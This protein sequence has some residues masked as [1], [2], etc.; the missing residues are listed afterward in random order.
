[1][2]E[3]YKG[4]VF[5]LNGLY[6]LTSREPCIMCAMALIHARVE[7]VYFCKEREKDGGI[8]GYELYSKCPPLNHKYFAF[9]ISLNT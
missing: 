1:M 6:V 7:R 5:N 3:L 8:I 4:E 2:I 9:K